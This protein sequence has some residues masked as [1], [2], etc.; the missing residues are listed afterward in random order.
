MKCAQYTA[1]NPKLEKMGLFRH[2][3]G[4]HEKIKGP[5]LMVEG[6]HHLRKAPTPTHVLPTWINV[7]SSMET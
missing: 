2:P 4:G 7:N 1:H 3:S 5:G 6:G